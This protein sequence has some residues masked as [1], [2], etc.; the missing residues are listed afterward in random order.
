MADG[1]GKG[2][3][4]G[5]HVQPFQ[6][7]ERIFGTT[8]HQPAGVQRNRFVG[9]ASF[10]TGKCGVGGLGGVVWCVDLCVFNVINHFGWFFLFL[11]GWFLFG[12]SLF[13]LLC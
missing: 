8:R 3:G 10:A 11:F 1:V 6:S 5:G 4:D 13:D 2:G 9:G 7:I 12:W